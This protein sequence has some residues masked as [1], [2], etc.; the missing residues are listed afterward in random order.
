MSEA[1]T[2]ELRGLGIPFFA[3]KHAL[4]ASRHASKKKTTEEQK[5]SSGSKGRLDHEDQ[6]LQKQ[7][8]L[9]RDDLLS[10]QRR[11]L[12]LLQDLCRE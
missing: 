12:E 1:M 8:T 5:D 4:V 11:M 3:I 7:G 2:S 10:L 6:Q 9:T